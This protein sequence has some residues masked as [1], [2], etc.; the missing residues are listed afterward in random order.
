MD[1]LCEHVGYLPLCEFLWD[2]SWSYPMVHSRWTV[3]PG[4]SACSNCSRW[5]LQLD[6]QLH[7]RHDLSIYTGTQKCKLCK[8]KI[9]VSLLYWDKIRHPSLPRLALL[10]ICLIFFRVCWMFTCSSYLLGC[11]SAS[12]CLLIF[13]SLRLK[14][15]PLKRSLPSSKRERKSWQRPP[16]IMLNWSS[17]KHPQMHETLDLCLCSQFVCM[18]KDFSVC[19]YFKCGHE[20]LAW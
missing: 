5:L 18:C 6:Q 3:Q 7:H 10:F 11:F 15:K 12:L 20:N 13:G 8:T 2:W 4:T 19:Q 16:K 9:D 14:A 1:E 17:S